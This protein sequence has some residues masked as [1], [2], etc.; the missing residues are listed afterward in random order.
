MTTTVPAERFRDVSAPAPD[1]DALAISIGELEASVSAADSIEVCLAAV[2]DWD[3]L[4]REVRTYESLVG[5]RFHQDTADPDRKRARQ[6][7]DEAQ[8]RWTQ[9]EVSVQRALLGHPRRAELELALGAQSFALWE[10]QVLAFDPAIKADLAHE[11]K[12][13]GEYGP[14]GLGRTLIP[15][16]RT[17]LSSI[18]K[19]RGAPTAHVATRPSLSTGS[20]RNQR[21]SPRPHLRRAGAAAARHGPRSSA[22]IT[23]SASATSG[24][25]ASTTTGATSSGCAPPSGRTWCRW[26][27]NSV[28]ARPT[29]GLERLMF[30]DEPCTTRPAT[31]PRSATT[32]GCSRAPRKCSTPWAA[33]A[34]LPPD[35]QRRPPRPDR[36]QGQAGGGFCTSFPT[37]GMPYVFA[38]FNGTKGDVEVFTHEMGHAFQSY[39][40]REQ[41][42]S[43]YLWPTYESCEIHSMS[44]EFLTWPP[45]SASSATTPSGSAACT[46]TSR[47]CS[48]RT[49]WPSTTSNT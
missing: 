23:T 28:A 11:A 5:L 42:L 44:L 48:C 47:C 43:D 21:P 7:W 15:G 46:W 49:A 2:R 18:V 38:N 26:P 41:P 30:W 14:F 39:E 40:S 24:C 45:W 13:G 4:R 22:S 29:L 1:L 10:S 8:P 12:L 19:F 9:L 34:L 3:A 32:T 37:H 17:N 36:P 20:G 6:A 31:P 35:G 27:S 16:E 25:A 33:S